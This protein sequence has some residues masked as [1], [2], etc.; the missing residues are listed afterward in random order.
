MVV[1][2]HYHYDHDYP[3]DNSAVGVDLA[4]DEEIAAAGG[5]LGRITGATYL[6][7]AEVPCSDDETGPMCDRATVIADI[8]QRFGGIAPYIPDALLAACGQ[9]LA[10]YLEDTDGIG[11]A[12]CVHTIKN[13]GRVIGVHGH[14]HEFGKTF[15]MT[16]NPGTPEERILLDIPNWSFEWQLV[17]RPTEEIIVDADDTLLI[18]CSWDRDI[19]PMPEPRYITWNEGTTDEMCYS[20]LTTM[21]AD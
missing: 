19:F 18:E 16:L 5:S 2:I 20:S 11:D 1:Q 4:S 21:P 14:M 6:A 10:P 17:Y 15:R 8:A 12:S 7:P 9:E 3:W 13:P